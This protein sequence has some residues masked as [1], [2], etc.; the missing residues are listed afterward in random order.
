[1]ADQA[2]PS[3]GGTTEKPR[4]ADGVELIG[5][6]EG[7]G[8]KEAPYIARRADG[9]VVQLAPLL[10]LIA[11]AADG[12]RTNEEIAAAVSEAI[13]RGVSADNV[14]QLV[15]ERLRPLGVIAG[16]NG[17]Q[18]EVQKADPMLALKL[19]A[20]L[21]PERVVNAI[22][23]VFKPLFFPP[24][25][26]AVLAG[27]VAL[28]VWLFAYHGVAQSLREVLYSPGLL[29][30]M[31]G[32][33]ILSAAFHE[34]GH[35]TACA[36]GGARPGAMGAGLYIV[37]PAFYTDVTDAY[38]LGK[39]ARLRTDLGGVYFNAI[40]I[41][42]TAG[43]YFLTGFEPLLLIIPFQ[44]LEMIHQFLPFI[45]LDGYYIVSDLTGVPDMFARIKPTL[46][47]VFMPWKK[48]SDRVTELKPWVRGAVTL[49]VLTVV[50]LLLFM[51][52]MMVI[53]APRIFSTAY[54]S[55]FVQYHK[56]QHDFSG[57]SALHGAIGIFQML[58][59]V[60]PAIGIIA[61]FWLLLKR[62]FGAVWTR[63]E[64]HPVPR[65]AFVVAVGTAAA[66]L[67]Y[68]WWPNGDYRPIQ[69]GER[70][71]IQGAVEQFAAIPTG[72][73][74]LTQTRQAALGGAPLVSSQQQS[75]DTT[76]PTAPATT[77]TTQTET[78][79]Q[80]TETQTTETGTGPSVT[81]PTP[82]TTVELTVST[83]TTTTTTP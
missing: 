66:F 54:D 70:G 63:T 40:F 38:R 83:T 45:R 27:L 12:Q 56:V 64:G 44:L 8:F 65:G 35:A 37:W 80:T 9:Q 10:H 29:M 79:T 47:S 58:I 48:T 24:V 17:S 71:T 1:M 76:K 39:G 25:V 77:T 49:Y 55:F 72:R 68:I 19:K 82:V 42:I 31:L 73:P 52:G 67:G 21:V 33:V 22:T 16:A 53:N 61:T 62:V 81:V 75:P 4:L 28:C 43:A 7:S 34:C 3:D 57:G 18:P 46:A 26:I 20:A 59:L 5:E 14:R 23:K 74:G 2:P 15:D 6:Y 60:L 41:L 69:K 13:K 30:M 78:Q 51:F 36:Y 50:P 32:L 11:E